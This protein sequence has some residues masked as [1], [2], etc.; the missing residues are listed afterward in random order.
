MQHSWKLNDNQFSIAD[1][2][3][4]AGFFLNPKNFWSQ[5]KRIAD[6]ESRMANF[7]GS[8]YAVFCSSGSTANTLLAMR[9]RDIEDKFPSFARSKRNTVVFP[10]I[11]WQTT[12]SP[13]IREGFDTHFIDISMKD[14]SMDLDALEKYLENNCKKVALVFIVSLLGFTPDIYRL[15]HIAEKYNVEIKLDNCENTFGYTSGYGIRK[16]ISSQ[17]TSTTSYYMGHC[18]QACGE[19]GMIFTNSKDEYEY[20]LM[21]RNHGMTRSV[22][23]LYGLDEWGDGGNPYRNEMVDPRFDF[24]MLGNNFRG[25]DVSAFVADLDMDRAEYYIE[26]RRYLYSLFKSNLNRYR[27]YLPDNE[28]DSEVRNVPFCLPII[29]NGNSDGLRDKAIKLCDSL[30]IESRP[31]VSSNIGRHTC[32]KHLLNYNEYQNAEKIHKDGFYVG[33]HAKVKPKD[34]VNLAQKLNNLC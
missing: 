29:V 4:I 6:F 12:Y 27:F 13:F 16:F 7:I 32:Y 18:L 24:Y 9:C 14:F 5:G 3:R 1:R 22:D 20:Y 23:H 30:G 10:S 19:G 8:K 11:G 17:F 34:V 33:L 21:A 15:R 26:Q 28:T 25:T 2:I 31:V